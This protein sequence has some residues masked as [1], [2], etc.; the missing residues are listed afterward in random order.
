[1]CYDLIQLQIIR[2]QYYILIVR[3]CAR[4]PA[5]LKM[6]FR[7]R[8]DSNFKTTLGIWHI[9]KLKLK[10]TSARAIKQRRREEGET[11]KMIPLGT[12]IFLAQLWRLN[13]TTVSGQGKIC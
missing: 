8:L 13:S 12:L 11:P 10:I 7:V 6:F 1:M 2:F 3:L 5:I 4:F 9:S